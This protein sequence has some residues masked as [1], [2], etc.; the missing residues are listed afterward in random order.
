MRF[1][2]KEWEIGKSQEACAF[3]QKPF[4]EEEEYFCALY[5]IEGGLERRDYCRGC[6]DAHKGEPF[7]FWKRRFQKEKEPRRRFIDNESLL[8]FFY[9]MQD[10]EET[11]SRN[12]AYIVGLILLRKK[13]FRLEGTERSGTHEA[14]LLRERS[15]NKLWRVVKPELTEHQIEELASEAGQ[16]LECEP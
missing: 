3:C 14:L 4:E 5:E 8:D 13:L 7:S 6:W 10:A 9:C 12:F 11:R 16:I 1:E 15:S 2:E